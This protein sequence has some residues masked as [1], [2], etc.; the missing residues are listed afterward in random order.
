MSCFRSISP[1]ASL[2]TLLGFV[3]ATGSSSC[4]GSTDHPN[5]VLMMADDLGF[6]DIGCYGSEISTPNLDR[7]AS[8][9]VRFGNF[10][11]TS[12]CC[13][14]RAALMTGLYSHQ[15]G[16]GGMTYQGGGPGY[17]GQLS[18]ATETLPEMLGKLGY[19]TAMV[20]KWHMSLSK[21][22]DDGPNGSWPLERGFERFYG[23]ME[24]AKNY[25]RPP[26]FFDNQT[27][28]HQFDDG[29]FYTEAISQRAADWIID[30]P[31][32][33]PLFL[34]VAFYAPH[35]PLQAP[36][37][38]IKKYRRR[39]LAGWD[40][41]RRERFENQMRL[42]IISASAEL[43]A[44]PA[45]VPA[46]ETLSEKQCDESDL[47]M[48]C[49]A[50]QVETLDAGVGRLLDAIE[51]SG[52]SKNTLVIFLSDNGA[53]S[54]GGPFGAGPTEKVGGPDAPIRTT[55]GKGW[56]TLS[57]TPFREHKANTHQGGVMAPL[58]LRWPA[59]IPSTGE[60]RFDLAHIVD[61]APT[62]LAAAGKNIDVPNFEGIDLL[63]QTRRPENA[64]YYEHE[65]SR[66]V[67]RGD[68]KLVNK[69]KS[70][71]W[72][73]YN[74]KLDPTEQHNLSQS[75]SDRVKQLKS[76]WLRWAERCHVKMK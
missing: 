27:E 46:W 24:G 53:A 30:Q 5:I 43:S 62:C 25:F 29:F 50:A 35:F 15:A 40:H 10:T 49:Y 67:R 72:E 19:S 59:K 52:R 13:P 2:L 12:R 65:K 70:Q 44:R 34:Y 71:Q 41:L 20:G 48:A 7:L 23:S 42:G 45:D 60:P 14:S 22:I 33:K 32:D 69:A 4:L 57:N 39:Y 73:L 74:V 16:L 37:K 18:S 8:A 28:L 54:S 75:Q 61:L 9:G 21:S 11:N 1:L 36:A 51:Q 38:T 47:R 31:T 63:H 66:A 64:I 3:V 6:S 56:A 55:Y 17:Q 58:I 68:W 76:L 26:W